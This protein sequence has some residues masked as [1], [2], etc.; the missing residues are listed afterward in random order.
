MNGIMALPIL[1]T[2]DD[3][4]AFVDYLRNKPTGALLSEAKAAIKNEVLDARKLS[5]YLTWDI[6]TKDGD[7][8][9]LSQRGW[10]LARKTK[11]EQVVF[12]EILN[13]IVPYRS[14]LEWTFHNNLEAVTNVDV[15][16]HWHEHHKDAVGTDNEDTIKN[17]AV[18]FFRLCEGAGLGELTIGRRG[19]TTRLVVN[20]NELKTFIEA[21]PSS[22]PWVGD[23]VTPEPK[24]TTEE[25]PKPSGEDKAKTSDETVT[26]PT[27]PL[28]PKE[29]RIFISHGKNMQIVEQVQTILETVS[30]KGEVAEAEE[31]SAIPVPEKV[32]TAMRRCTAGIIIVS[33]EEGKKDDK[34]KFVINHNVL[35]E[36]GAAFVLYD[37]RVILLWDKRLEV[38]S[39][40]QG[41][42]RCEFEGNKLE[43]ADGMKLMKGIGSF[44]Q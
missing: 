15:A 9:K 7:R 13:G 8:F 11:T 1:T 43:W 20:R 22:P 29:L 2:T 31:T 10:D 23:V 17:Q 5:A 3:V 40:L 24:K 14:V 30:I 36:I 34:G 19:Q 21:G 35:I 32:F 44:K 4:K 12:K 28:T 42:Y 39:N 27:L 41:L 26:P 33:V 18:C 16:A 25:V 38:P 37:K 6:V